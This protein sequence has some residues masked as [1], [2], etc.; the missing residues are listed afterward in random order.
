MGK[1][2]VASVRHTHRCKKSLGHK[3]PV[4]K[5]FE[6]IYAKHSLNLCNWNSGKL[7]DHRFLCKNGWRRILLLR[8]NLFSPQLSSS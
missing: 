3:G 5:S 4:I 7:G 2:A 8:L 1:N 6:N